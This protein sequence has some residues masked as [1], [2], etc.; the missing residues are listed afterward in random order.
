MVALTNGYQLKNLVGSHDLQL[1]S[2]Y[3]QTP[4]STRIWRALYSGGCRTARG[5]VI[6]RFSRQEQTCLRPD[7]TRK[8]RKVGEVGEVGK[9]GKVGKIG[10]VGKK[11]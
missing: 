11:R 2:G 4:D 3:C 1:P 8:S 6:A 5:L 7:Q 10:K 9:V